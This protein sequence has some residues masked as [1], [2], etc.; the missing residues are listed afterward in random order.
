MVNIL[1]GY[2]TGAGTEFSR[3][4][5]LQ[6][7]WYSTDS[8]NCWDCLRYGSLYIVTLSFSL[9]TGPLSRC[10]MSP[11]SHSS[12][13]RRVTCAEDRPCR[14]VVKVGVWN[15]LVADGFTVLIIVFES[16]RG[17][18][19]MKKRRKYGFV[20]IRRCFFWGGRLN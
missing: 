1:S 3:G 18:S 13:C 4:K 8:L 20:S 7:Q 15:F 9:M 14:R 5:G 10:L 11:L 16:L 6:G 19:R 2:R 17:R 12:L